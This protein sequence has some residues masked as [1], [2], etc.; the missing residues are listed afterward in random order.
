MTFGH[1]LQIV[2][3]I[4]GF[5]T[6]AVAG[7]ETLQNEWSKSSEKIAMVEQRITANEAVVAA[8]AAADSAVNA[9]MRQKLNEISRDVSALSVLVARELDGHSRR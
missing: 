1:V 6:G 7:Y 4:A 5:T 9:E 3:L 8:H 2:M